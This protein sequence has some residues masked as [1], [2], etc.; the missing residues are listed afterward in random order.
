MT[1]EPNTF[2]FL[3]GLGAVDYIKA[4]DKQLSLLGHGLEFFKPK[5]RLLPGSGFRGDLHLSF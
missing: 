1:L 2:L 4:F 3:K 5:V